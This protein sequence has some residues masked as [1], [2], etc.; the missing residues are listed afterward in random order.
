MQITVIFK[1]RAEKSIKESENEEKTCNL[2]CNLQIALACNCDFRTLVMTHGRDGWNKA[3]KCQ[4][5]RFLLAWVKT[6]SK[7]TPR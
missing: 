5:L 3:E 2:H 6:R 4:K 1:F 7:S